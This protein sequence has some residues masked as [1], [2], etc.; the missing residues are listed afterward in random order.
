MGV[1]TMQEAKLSYRK[2]ARQFES[3]EHK[4]VAAW[5]RV[6]LEKGQKALQWSAGAAPVKTA[7]AAIK[8]L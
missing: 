4:H 5:E 2:A 3:D 8:G 7:K 1:E 6:Y